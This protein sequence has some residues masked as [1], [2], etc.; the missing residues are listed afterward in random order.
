[1]VAFS[2]FLPLVT[3]LGNYLKM[4]LDHY[5]VLKTTGQEAGPDIVA[6]FLE[7]KMQAW[8]PKLSGKDLLDDETRHAAA[9]FLAGVAVN[10]TKE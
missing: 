1:M 9:R 7:A 2:K 8:Q 5:A 10:Y 6:A 3:Q 4:G